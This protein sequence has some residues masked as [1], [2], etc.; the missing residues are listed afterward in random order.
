M[1]AEDWEEVAPSGG[2][3]WDTA[4]NVG[5]TADDFVRAAANAV[6]FGMADRFA[7]AMEG[8]ATGKGYDKALQEEVAKSE[9]ARSRSPYAS[10]AGDVSGALALPGF[11]AEALAARYGSG[12][13]ARAL[14]YGVTG[15]ATGAAQGAG[16]T[17]TGNLSDYATNALIGGAL[18]GTLG[19]GGGA[20]FGARPSVSRAATPTSPQL[21]DIAQAN[22][23]TLAQSGAAYEPQAFYKAADDL[24]RKL[25]TERY[26][27]RDSPAT[28]RAL[29]EMRGGGAPGQLNT[30]FDAIIDPASIDFIRKGINR[31]PKTEATATDRSSAEIV[32]RALDDFITNPPKGAV[33]PGTEREAERAAQRAMEA[34]GNWAAYKRTEALDDLISNAQNTAGATYSG[35]NLQ[36]ELRKGIRSFV[37]QK[38]GES[39]ASKAGFTDPEVAAFTQYTRGTTPT[40]LLRY[41]SNAMGGGGGSVGIAGGIVG[42]GA[43]G[44]A[45]GKYFH[46]DPEAGTAALGLLTPV[47]GAGLRMIGNRRANT[48]I[49]QLRDLIAQRSPAYDY[50]KLFAGTRPG[51][52][53]APRTA[54]ATRDAIAL[55]IL[56]K[57][58]QPSAQSDWQ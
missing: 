45:Y 1:A 4:R 54:K 29:E 37:R 33:L 50:R 9:A 34:R 6:T 36:N 22:Y 23:R 28:W 32:R 44:G 46:D 31:I 18:G 3:W 16:G 30:G 8:A 42:G 24:E 25:L 20:A 57:R 7:G 48:E 38:G 19:A 21:H 5:Q 40:N 41:A 56:K 10:L 11:G 51:P 14:G 17:Y 2:S 13:G 35:L 27:W 58:A 49:N 39:Q 43:L 52:G 12:L 55:E 15:A 26:H 53:S 47:V